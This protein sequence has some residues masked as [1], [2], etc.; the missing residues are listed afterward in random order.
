MGNISRSLIAR[1]AAVLVLGLTPV[2]HAQDSHSGGHTSGGSS[3]HNDGHAGGGKGPQYMGGD[4]G[5]GHSSQ[6][7][8]GGTHHHDS[9]TTGSK[10]VEDKIF[11]SGR[12]KGG[13]KFM[14]G[15]A[16]EGGT[17]HESGG[18]HH[19]GGTEHSH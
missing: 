16:A 8:K 2:G 6:T 1:M 11:S 3:G 5:S 14:G 15:K 12:G 7:H 10:T 4:R 18:D 9:S 19:D 17:G 13:P